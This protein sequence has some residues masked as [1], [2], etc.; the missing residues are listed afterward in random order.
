MAERV[1]VTG[2]TGF[3]GSHVAR[4][5][6]EIEGKNVAI[7]TRPGADRTRIADLIDRITIIEGDLSLSGAWEAAVRSWAPELC[8]HLAW[9]ATPGAYLRALE[10]LDC[11]TAG[12]SLLRLLDEADCRRLVLAG[13]CFEY[14]TAAGYLDETAP[15]RP[16]SLYAA[17][18]QALFLLSAQFQRQRGRSFAGA[19]LFYQYGPNEDERRLVP[20]V[21][22]HLLRGEP[23]A[24]TSGEQVRD[25][26]HI[27]DVAAAICAIG[28]S[29]VEGPVNI[30]SGQPITVAALA[31]KIAESIGRPDLIHLGTRET[32]PG[33]P[34]FI[35]A[36]PARLRGETGWRPAYTV[37]VGLESTISWWR[38]RYPC[39]EN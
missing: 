18:K 16:Q 22:T 4:R 33:D 12:L 13:T 15:I 23:C 29:A 28:E 35:C 24:L 6:V 37:E 25:F 38:E 30:G 26:L 31:K 5:L 36:N 7:L 9:Y 27:E 34:P 8:L 39:K 14:D 17:A 19:R 1:L 20:H 11:V 10:N 2:A 32:P 21:I 3:V